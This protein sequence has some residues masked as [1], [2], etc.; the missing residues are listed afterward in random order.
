VLTENVLDLLNFLV[1]GRGRNLD[2]P[3]VPR[4]KSHDSETLANQQK[5]NR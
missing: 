5:E 4:L 3:P 2:H 1:E